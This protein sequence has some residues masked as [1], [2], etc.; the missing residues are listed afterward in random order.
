[1]IPTRR[2][3]LALLL[4]AIALPTPGLR[5]QASEAALCPAADTVAATAPS[6]DLY[7]LELVPVPGLRQASGAVELGTV[8]SPFGIA[9][10][11]DGRHVYDLS[12]TLRDLPPPASLGPYAAYVAWAAPPSLEPML[13]LGA[14]AAGRTHLGRVALNKF[15][16]FVSAEPS[17]DV[18]RRTGPL[19]L[20]G[21]SPSMRMGDTHLLGLGSAPAAHA[22]HAADGGWPMPPL[23]PRVSPMPMPGLEGAVPAAAPYLPGGGVD[24]ARLPLARPRE[25]LD[26]ADGDTL[27]LEAGLVRRRLKGRDLVM[28]AFNGQHPGPLVRVRQGATIFVDFR[29]ATGWPTAVHW[30]GVRLDNAFDGVPHLTQALVEPGGRFLYRVRFRDAGIYWYHPHHRA[31]LLQDLGLARE[32]AGALA[33]RPATTGRRTA[34]RCSCSTT[35]SWA[36]PGWCRTARDRATHALMG[37]FGNVMLVNG[38]PRWRLDARRGEVVRF[39]LTN[40]GNVRVFNLSFAGARMKVVAADVGRFEREEWVESVAIAP[41]ERYVVDVRFDRPG[42]RRPPQ[43]RPG[44]G[45]RRGPLLRGR[46]GHPGHRSASPPPRPCP[47]WRPPSGGCASTARSR[48]R[49]SA[50]ARTSAARRTC[51]LVLTL[52]NRGLPFALEQ[53]LRLDAPYFNPVEWSGHHADDGLAPHHRPG[54]LG[55]ARAGDGAGEHGHRTG[56]SAWA[57]WSSSGSLNDRTHPARHA[58]P[59]ARARAALPG[60]GRQNGVPTDEPG[61]EG[62]RAG[63]GGRHGRRAAGALQPGP[64]DAALPHR[65]APGGGDADRLHG[66]VA[67]ELD[68]SPRSGARSTRPGRHPPSHGGVPM[69]RIRVAALLA[70]ALAGATRSARPALD[71][72]KP[73]VRGF[74]SVDAPVVALTHV[75][76]IDGTGAAPAAEQTIVIENGTHRRG[77]AGARRCG[78]RRARGCMDLAGHTVIPGLV[79]LHDHTFYTT[80]APAR[81]GQLH[82]APPV[83]GERRDH[84]PHHREHARRTTSST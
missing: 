48:A 10:T 57:T 45:P 23:D 17:A 63:A 67:R 69:R 83:S 4:G 82:R 72:L 52:E 16:V 2:L 58:A 33:R 47:T 7:C 30:H 44:D 75:Q 54:A 37:R 50:T 21:A 53:L 60:A 70:L 61:L 56:A 14:V 5:A 64:L 62:H 68:R 26:L 34:R 3:A 39:H 18:A 15:L 25:L 13:R 59:H 29:N 41:A 9:L 76:V 84:D 65:R 35:S 42:E 80:P 49:S 73:G 28:F 51:E 66:P 11:A 27:R 78:S 43:P 12:I 20:R 46:D 19:V 6:R 71:A 74:V 1:M 77:G 40:A 31:D 8:P 22:R 55:A 24:P 81:A 32:P 38:E 36:T 79:G